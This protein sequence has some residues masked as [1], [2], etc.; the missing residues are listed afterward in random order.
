GPDSVVLLDIL[1][2][3]GA[4]VAV[5]HVHH[6]LRA[7]SDEEAEFVRARAAHYRIPFYLRLVDV[8]GRMAEMGESLETAA[9]ELR[10]VALREMAAEA[11]AQYIATGHNADDQAET[12]LMRILRGTGVRGLGGI[13]PCNEE[14]IRPLLQVWRAEILDF[15]RENELPYRLDPSN[16]SPAHQRNRLRHRLLP[17][18]EDEYAPRLR[19]RLAHLADIA[20]GDNAALE[21]WAATCYQQY[22]QPTPHGISLPHPLEVPEAICTRVWLLALAA[23][24]GDAADIGYDHLRAIAMLHTGEET[25][26]PGAIVRWE[27]DRLVFL[28]QEIVVVAY[29]SALPV[30]GV[31]E[32]PSIGVILNTELLAQWSSTPGGDAALVDAEAIV[33]ELTVRGWRAGDRYQPLG[34]P[35]TR[36]LQDIFVDAQLPR[37][38]RARVPVVCD[39]EGIVWLAGYRLAD[40]VKIGRKTDK[41]LLIK[42]KWEFNPWT[43]R[44]SADA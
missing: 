17:L 26:L 13:P 25:H 43:L 19:E 23:V 15:A 32:L 42:I 31:V 36:K 7:E 3:L 30:P 4:S 20:R 41:G 40:R 35:G 16:N 5:G 38:L 12:V 24:R 9:R 8:R 34:A 10:R 39:E 18:L 11:G 14:F 33:G 1:C 27:Y 28:P 22:A 2:R 29:N 44:N 37:R 6:G 21:Q